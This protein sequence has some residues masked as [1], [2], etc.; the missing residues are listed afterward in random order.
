[1]ACERTRNTNVRMSFWVVRRACAGA[2]HSDFRKRAREIKL[3]KRAFTWMS[4]NYDD[5]GD[6]YIIAKAECPDRGAL[7]DWIIR[8]DCLSPDCRDGIAGDIR[9]GWCKYQ[10][11]S[12]WMDET[13]PR[14]AYLVEERASCPKHLDGRN[15]PGW[16]PV[17][18][19]RKGEWY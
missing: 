16:F 15:K 13:G 14:G 11:R 7:P 18:I 4:W 9:E 8:E 19:I 1:M 12:D 6:A 10:C 3:K 5:D 2:S 17:W